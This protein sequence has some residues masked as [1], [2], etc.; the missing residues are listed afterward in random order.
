MIIG[1][2]K[3]RPGATA[4]TDEGRALGYAELVVEAETVA[5]GLA[6]LGA[7]PGE[8]V[9]LHLANSVDFVVAALGCLWL[10]AI[11][12]PLAVGDPPERL[13]RVVADCNPSVVVSGQAHLDYRDR[14]LAGERAWTTLDELR[15]AGRVHHF[16]PAAT[17]AAATSTTWHAAG[18]VP[19]AEGG[20][21]YIV[22]TSGTTG[23]PKGVLI[24]NAAFAA[25]VKATAAAVGMSPATRS[26]CVSPVYFD[27]SFAT[28]FTTLASGGHLVMRSRELLLFPRNFFAVVDQEAITCTGF[29]PTYLRLLLSSRDAR[30]LGTSTL[31]CVALGGEASSV[32]DVQG[33][34]AVAPDVRVFNRYG[35]TETTIAVTHAP[36]TRKALAGGAVPI[37]LPHPGV[38]FYLFDEDGNEVTEQGRPGEL[39]IGGDQLMEGYWGAEE[40]TAMVLRTDLVAGQA[41]YRTGDIAYRGPS[42][43]YFCLGRT[44]RVLKRHG[45]RISLVE[46][47]QVVSGAP[48][49]A[50]SAC[51]AFDAAGHAGI[52][53]FVVAGQGAPLDPAAVTIHASR[54]LPANMLPDRVE[55]VPA[56]PLTPTGKLDESELLRQAGLAPVQ[57]Q[58]APGSTAHPQSSRA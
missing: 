11:F 41:L 49:V 37:G 32:A 35:P 55:V 15:S 45:T 4:V 22:Y 53:A 34:W 16:G 42:G 18:S 48:G 3:S 7:A 23:S 54:L 9:C 14:P 52:A 28:I 36:L 13:G 10:G 47:N 24:G 21:A 29:S 26:L 5:N 20:H 46:V 58:V 12:V 6:A 44:D 38:T 51:L 2:S 43:D 40:L 25:A 30:R 39:C 57:A 19:P 1:Q 31:E 56:M 27:A 17:G 50:G 33:L 8:R